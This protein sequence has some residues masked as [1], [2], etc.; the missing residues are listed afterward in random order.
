MNVYLCSPLSCPYS[1]LQRLAFPLSTLQPGAH[2]AHSPRSLTHVSK[3]SV[4]L[5][6]LMFRRLC[7][8]D[9]LAVTSDMLR[10]QSQQTSC[11]SGAYH[12]STLPFT[13]VLEPQV[14]G[15]CCRHI[16]CPLPTL[17]WNITFQS[18][19]FL[20]LI[21][22]SQKILNREILEKRCLNV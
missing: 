3:P 18:F 12:L 8:R 1:A 20:S 13:T 16:C 11:P 10:K 6:R 21:A 22:A 9:F 4:V 19:S 17:L 15:L 7:W 2:F 14:P 5:V